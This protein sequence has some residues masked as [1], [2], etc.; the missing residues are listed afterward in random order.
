MVRYGI[1]VDFTNLPS[2]LSAIQNIPL[3]G[4]VGK[5]TVAV[6]LAF[7]LAKRGLRV[8]ILDA[9]IY[10]PSLPYMVQPISDVVR[11][12]PSNPKNILPLET[13][14]G[15]KMLSF[16]HV[17]PKSGVQGAGGREAAVLRGPVASKVI[18]Q[19]ISSTEWGDLDYLVTK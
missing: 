3:A 11:R 1:Q 17:S 7:A 12:S 18:T 2:S 8:G 9:D 14:H 5:S 19:M 10:G 13:S 6:N 16:G 4:G 15:I